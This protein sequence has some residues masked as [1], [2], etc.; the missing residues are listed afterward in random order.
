MFILS[1]NEGQFCH[2][3]IKNIVCFVEQICS[4]QHATFFASKGVYMCK[5]VCV[6]WPTP[7]FGESHRDESDTISDLIISPKMKTINTTDE[8]TSRNKK[9]LIV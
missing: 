7:I 4:F 2:I 3:L 9:T 8:G 1:K 6:S 5:N